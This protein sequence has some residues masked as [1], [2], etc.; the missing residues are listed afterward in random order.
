MEGSEV[1]E[2][3]AKEVEGRVVKNIELKLHYGE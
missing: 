2:H 1:G 3:G